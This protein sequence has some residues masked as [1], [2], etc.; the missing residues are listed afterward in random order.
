MEC[1]WSEA[2]FLL[3]FI[4][5]EYN[6]NFC[7][8]ANFWPYS[9]FLRRGGFFRKGEIQLINIHIQLWSHFWDF[10]DVFRI[11]VKKT[12]SSPNSILPTR[13]VFQLQNSYFQNDFFFILKCQTNFAKKSLLMRNTT[14][15]PKTSKISTFQMKISTKEPLLVLH[16]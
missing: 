13:D 4:H 8:K 3:S 5:K 10:S 1:C 7:L 9:F 16:T 6:I 2:F 12:K 15:Q 11:L 14:Y